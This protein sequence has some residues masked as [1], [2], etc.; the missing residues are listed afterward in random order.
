VP[1][2]ASTTWPVLSAAVCSI[3]VTV[4]VYA[5]RS[6]IPS[7]DRYLLSTV[8]VLVVMSLLPVLI[9]IRRSRTPEQP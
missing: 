3:C 6:R 4:A 1:A 2:R 7:I 9:D 5:L 8:A